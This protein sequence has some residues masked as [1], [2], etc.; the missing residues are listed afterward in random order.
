MSAAW[1][2]VPLGEVVDY[3]KEFIV[4]DDLQTYRRPRVQL[5]AQGIVLRDEIPGAMIKTKKQQVVKAKDF[6]VA[7]I[8]AKVGGFGIVPDDLGGAIVSSHYF[9]FHHR[10][11]RLDNRFLGW[12][13]KT[14]S[15]RQQVEAQ[16]STNYAAI[17][18]GDV[19]SYEMPL[20]PLDEQRR[21]VAIIDDLASKTTQA[22]TLRVTAL[23]EI[24]A[25]QRSA[26]RRLFEGLTASAVPLEEVCEAIIDNLHS[27]PV[28]SDGATVPCIRSPDVGFGTLD[29]EGARKTDEDEYVRRTIRG[30]PQAD[31]I[32][33]V[34]EGGGTGKCAL[35]APGQRFS[36]GQRVMMLRPDKSRVLPQFFLHQL[37]S[38]VIQEDHILPLSKGSASP[39]LNIGALRRFPFILPSL[40]EQEELV[41]KLNALQSKARGIK[42][43]QSETAAELDAMIPS[44]LDK[45][46]R[47]GL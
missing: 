34:R 5:H 27:T 9:L 40:S 31:D 12:F 36:L 7:E 24:E 46:F 38:P 13:I 42:L 22:V 41:R 10:P 37:L 21:I 8:D 18:P 45:A 26:S 25:L 20:P 35:V 6:L 11:A 15:F 39:H 47:G 2:I 44:I 4:I 33:L 1:P 43:L 17:R 3:R 30:E 16:G 19:L 23:A 28:Y 32:V 14:P 29:L